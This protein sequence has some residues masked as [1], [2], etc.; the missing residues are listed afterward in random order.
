[1]VYVKYGFAAVGLSLVLLIIVGFFMS[2]EAEVERS[3]N[4]DADREMV[5]EVLNNI[6]TWEDWMY[7]KDI[8]QEVYFRYH[9]PSRGRRAA[10]DWRSD[11]PEVSSGRVRIIESDPPEY[12]EAYVEHDEDGPEE[13]TYKFELETDEVYTHLSWT[14]EIKFTDNPFL[15]FLALSIDDIEGPKME[16]G[17]EN[18]KELS[19]EKFRE[20]R[21]L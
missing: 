9:G 10:V 21:E 6:K 19:E 8:D 3:V 12:I 14:Q 5:F 2:N 17:L 16:K 20:E 1:M 4:I 13:L 15:A 11:N 18:L 7:W